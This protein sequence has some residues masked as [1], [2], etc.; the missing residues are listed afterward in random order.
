[1]ATATVYIAAADLQLT[2]SYEEL[3]D[4][5]YLST[6]TDDKS[7]AA[8]E[9]PEGHAVRLDADGHITH[10]TVINARRL[11]DRD[12]ELV[13]TLRD[14]RLLRLTRADVADVMD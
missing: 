10:I 9:T 14:G 5:L 1:M 4:V 11:L 6:T 8:Q 3:G 13:A 2:G 7:A 12:G